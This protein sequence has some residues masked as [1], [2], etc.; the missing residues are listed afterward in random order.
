MQVLFHFRNSY[1]GGKKLLALKRPFFIYASNE[2]G[3]YLKPGG[4]NEI[5]IS[6]RSNSNN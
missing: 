1:S 5:T 2:P 3:R 6:S 4:D